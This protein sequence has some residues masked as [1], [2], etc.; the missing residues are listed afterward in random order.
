MLTAVVW[1]NI[2]TWNSTLETLLRHWLVLIKLWVC[3]SSCFT[4]KLRSTWSVKLWKFSIL[5]RSLTSLTLLWWHLSISH[6][7]IVLACILLIIDRIFKFGLQLL[8]VFE[9]IKCRQFKALCNLVLMLVEFYN[10][11]SC[12]MMI[13][14]FLCLILTS[15]VSFC[16]WFC[17]CTWEDDLTFLNDL[18]SSLLKLT[19]SRMI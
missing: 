4:N 2:F 7:I 16:S 19:V 10:L 17:Q 18:I 15:L 5:K 9:A 8:Y 6:R 11:V 1:H 12:D 13:F 3:V 14:I